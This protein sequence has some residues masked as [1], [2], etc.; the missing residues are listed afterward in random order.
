MGYGHCMGLSGL[1]CEES[2]M[3]DAALRSHLARAKTIAVVGHSDKPQRPSYQIA[4]YLRQVGYRVYPVNPAIAT[5]DG[6]PSY[7]S[8][9]SVTAVNVP[10]PI[11]I[12]TVFRRSE[13]VPE[14][15][16]DAIAVGAKLIWLQ[17]GIVHIEAA[18]KAESAGIPTVMDR[19]IKIE[20]QRLGLS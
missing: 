1:M 13:A 6:E 7:P 3:D 18:A 5:I 9:A 19:C 17:Q 10:G 11:D 4:Q 20:Y 15:V 12:V 8:L 14:I 16:N 2:G